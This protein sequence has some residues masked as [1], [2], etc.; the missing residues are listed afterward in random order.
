MRKWLLCC[1]LLSVGT[2]GAAPLF[3]TSY[4]VWVEDAVRT[5]RE[6][7]IFSAGLL[8]E[9]AISRNELAPVL[10]RY[11][12]SQEKA[13]QNFAPRSDLNEVRGVLQ[14]VDQAAQDLNRRVQ[15]LEGNTQQLEQRP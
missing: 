2:A 3:T 4:P 14:G 13:Q 15:G 7:G 8:P 10:E 1:W 11:L 9:Q 12:Q 6:Q 5:L